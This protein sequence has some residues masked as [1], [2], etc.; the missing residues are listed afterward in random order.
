MRRYAIWLV[1]VRMIS[2]FMKIGCGSRALKNPKGKEYNGQCIS[3]NRDKEEIVTYATLFAYNEPIS[4]KKYMNNP[5]LK[6]VPFECTIKEW[7][8]K[9]YNN[10]SIKPCD[11]PWANGSFSE[12]KNAMNTLSKNESQC[13]GT[14]HNPFYI[15]IG[16]YMINIHHI[17]SLRVQKTQTRFLIILLQNNGSL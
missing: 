12:I 4:C 11:K 17:R 7:N 16:L 15:V 5:S 3:N 14:P 6:N 10:D 2:N 1:Q 9:C 13:F 8:K